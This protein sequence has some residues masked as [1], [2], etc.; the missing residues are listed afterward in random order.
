M[1]DERIG[2]S[3][4]RSDIATFFRATRVTPYVDATGVFRPTGE[5]LLQIQNRVL[6][7][8]GD[9]VR[10][11][12]YRSTVGWAALGVR[13]GLPVGEQW[14]LMGAVENGLD[15]NYRV[16]GSG[17]DAAGVNVYLNLSYRF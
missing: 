9:T 11:P 4:R 17:M 13:V 16:H 14:Q 1:D 3:F 2:A 15:R 7:G 8:V 12:L 10:V 5:T 6:P